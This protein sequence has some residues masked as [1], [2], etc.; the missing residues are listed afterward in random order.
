MPGRKNRRALW[1]VGEGTADTL[2]GPVG[3]A[4]TPREVTLNRNLKVGKEPA[5]RQL[6][7]RKDHCKGSRLDK[8]DDLQT[9]EEGQRGHSRAREKGT[10]EVKS[11]RQGGPDYQA[12]EHPIFIML[13]YF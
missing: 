12:M 1:R 6:S 10:G 2:A 13:I 11:E 4:P 9:R 3:R 7:R 5:R 8:G